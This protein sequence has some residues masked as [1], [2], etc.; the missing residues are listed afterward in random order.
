MGGHDDAGCDNN[1]QNNHHHH[2]NNNNSNNND[3]MVPIIDGSQTRKN[4]K[5]TPVQIFI[6]TLMM[7]GFVVFI[8]VQ[9][10]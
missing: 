7:L 4:K 3:Q 5:V 9:T 6:V 1:Q 2:D 8:I 10:T